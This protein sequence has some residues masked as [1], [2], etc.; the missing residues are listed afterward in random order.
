MTVLPARRNSDAKL[1]PV[2]SDPVS[3]AYPRL[4]TRISAV[5]HQKDL[6]VTSL[7]HSERMV[8]I[9]VVHTSSLVLHCFA[10]G[11]EECFFQG[12]SGFGQF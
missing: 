11:F 4:K 12:C 8:L 3:A 1:S 2:A 5:V 10:G 6:V 7:V 9:I